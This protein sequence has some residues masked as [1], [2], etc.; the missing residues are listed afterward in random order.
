MDG[1]AVIEDVSAQIRQYPAI[2]WNTSLRVRLRYASGMAVLSIGETTPLIPV[3]LIAKSTVRLLAIAIALTSSAGAQTRV[4]EFGAFN[5]FYA[6]STLPF[7]S[8][9]F[10][11]IKDSDYQPAFEAGIYE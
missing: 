1:H 9:P 5:P 4:P 2:P 7:Q 11:R 10:D 3:S 6:P 8:P